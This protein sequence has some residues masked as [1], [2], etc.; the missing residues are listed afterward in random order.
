MKNLIQDGK[1][2]KLTI[3]AGG[4]SGDPIMVGNIKGV[5]SV[6]IAAGEAGAVMT[7]GVFDLSVEAVNDDGNSAVAVGD[8]L[9]YN[10]SDTPVLTKKNSGS[11]F[12]LALEAITSGETDTINVFVPRGMG[13]GT[14]DILADTI[15]ASEIKNDAVS[16]EHLDDGVLPSHVIKFAGTATTAGGAAAEDIAVVGALANDVAIVTIKDNGT[17]NVTLLQSVAATDKIT[18]TFSADPGNDAIINYMILRAAA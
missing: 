11:F 9:F 17:N 3:A 18:C 8:Q 6:N 4:S 12:G 1:S 16:L 7:E 5:L 13:P 15:G 14:V 10:G 2:L